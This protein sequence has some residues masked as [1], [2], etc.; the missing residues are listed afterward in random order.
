MSILGKAERTPNAKKKECH[1]FNR[2]CNLDDII[3]R[4]K[5]EHSIIHVILTKLL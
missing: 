1:D 4:E 5:N 3:Y 2:E